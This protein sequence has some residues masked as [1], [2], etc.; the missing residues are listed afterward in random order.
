MLHPTEAGALP[1]E[2]RPL[3]RQELTS[4]LILTLFSFSFQ[5]FSVIIQPSQA[6]NSTLETVS[7]YRDTKRLRGADERAG[8][9]TERR[10]SKRPLACGSCRP[11]SA[12]LAG[13]SWS[14]GPASGHLQG[15][16][17]SSSG[18]AAGLDWVATRCQSTHG[19]CPH[20]LASA[21]S[22]LVMLVMDFES[23]KT[24]LTT[25]LV[26]VMPRWSISHPYCLCSSETAYKKDSLLR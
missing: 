5:F 21:F 4:C 6:H 2:A 17:W 14:G 8:L 19:S 20:M 12:A 10:C 26:L 3:P 24:K 7:V 11:S 1:A 22:K 16:P 23:T 18:T 13:L 25:I 9:R 15:T